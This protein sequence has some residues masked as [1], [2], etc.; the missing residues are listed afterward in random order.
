[1]VVVVLFLPFPTRLLAE[2]IGESNPSASRPHKRGLAPPTLW[3]ANQRDPRS[4]VAS[5]DGS[6]LPVNPSDEHAFS[7][8]RFRVQQHRA[9]S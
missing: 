4:A 6:D 2:Y 1:M 8:R 9:T 5:A 7:Y 3:Q